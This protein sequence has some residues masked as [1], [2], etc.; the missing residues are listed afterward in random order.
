M[1]MTRAKNLA[2]GFI[3]LIALLLVLASLELIYPGALSS[4]SP[5]EERPIIRGMN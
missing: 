2:S 3:A 5:D 4:G 1:T